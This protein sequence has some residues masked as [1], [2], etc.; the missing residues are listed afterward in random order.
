MNRHVHSFQLA[1]SGMRYALTTQ[2][3]F[4]VHA[5]F[6]CLALG[7]GLTLHISSLE[8]VAVVLAI[9]LV[10]VAEMINTSIELMTDLITT[11]HR[12]HAKIAKDVSAGMVLVAALGAV[13]IAALIFLP[14]IIVR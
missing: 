3:N 4:V 5:V 14:K 13:A 9:V 10:F 12:Q 2:L 6:A 8:W 7:L 1:F 11:E